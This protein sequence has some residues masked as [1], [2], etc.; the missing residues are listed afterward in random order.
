M[1]RLPLLLLLGLLAA[2]AGLRSYSRGSA[3]SMRDLL[4][5]ALQ[6]LERSGYE[7][8]LVDSVG[9][10][11]QGH[12][13]ITGIRE[14]A[15]RGAAAATG[16]ITG[17]LAGGPLT[18][19]D[20]L[21]VFVYQRHYPRGTAIEATAGLLTVTDGNQEQ[22]SPTDAAKRDARRLVTTCAATG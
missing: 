22:G 1:R 13:E 5:C 15:R 3:A 10:L 8:V 19:Y 21:T 11:L 6:E 7:P 16:V 18:R 12:R 4:T 20:E 2:C 17:G 9:G 14:S